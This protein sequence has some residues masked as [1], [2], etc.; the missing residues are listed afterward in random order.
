MPAKKVVKQLQIHI[1][2]QLLLYNYLLSNS[3]TCVVHMKHMY[4]VCHVVNFTNFVCRCLKISFLQHI[5]LSYNSNCNVLMMLSL[6]VMQYSHLSCSDDNFS[7]G[8]PELR[9]STKNC[10]QL[11]RSDS[12]PVSLVCVNCFSCCYLWLLHVTDTFQMYNS[13]NCSFQMPPQL[14]T[15][16]ERE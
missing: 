7:I 4:S 10:R 5:V 11:F 16:N 8:T 6:S 9:T 1:M 12:K 14:C 15:G 3:C 13:K 2:H